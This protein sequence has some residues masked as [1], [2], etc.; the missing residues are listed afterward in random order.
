MILATDV[1][2]IASGISESAPL[3]INPTIIGIGVGYRL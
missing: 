1:T 2:A 3:T